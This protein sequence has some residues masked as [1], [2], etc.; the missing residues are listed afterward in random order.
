MDRVRDFPG[1]KPKKERPVRYAEMVFAFQGEQLWLR[2]KVERGVWHGL[3]VP[4]MLEGDA[5]IT[6]LDISALLRVR[7]EEVRRVIR[8]QAMVHDFTH[9]RLIIH[10]VAIDLEQMVRVEGY[11][12][13]NDRTPGVGLPAPVDKLLKVCLEER[14]LRPTLW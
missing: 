10:P 14:D 8:L 11:Q 12:L 9:Y 13:F 4:P 2:R 1:K 5:P 6:A 7:Q 3:W